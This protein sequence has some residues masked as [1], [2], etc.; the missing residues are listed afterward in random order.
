M[1]AQSKDPAPPAATARPKFDR[2]DQ[3]IAWLM[4]HKHQINQMDKGKLLFNFAGDSFQP[5]LTQVFERQGALK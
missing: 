4:T 5:D 1:S 3:L 2:V